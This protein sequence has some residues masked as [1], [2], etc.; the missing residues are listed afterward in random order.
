MFSKLKCI[1]AGNDLRRK[2]KQSKPTQNH[3]GRNQYCKMQA[4]MHVNAA[5]NISGVSQRRTESL[6]GVETHRSQQV[7][8]HNSHGAKSRRAANER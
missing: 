7:H 4:H 1:L 5:K 8:P 2:S 6:C 3:P